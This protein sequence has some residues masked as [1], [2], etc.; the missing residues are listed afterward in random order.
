MR[1]VHCQCIPRFVTHDKIEHRVDVCRELLEHFKTEG[2]D[3]LHNIVTVDKSLMNYYAPE[4]KQQSSQWKG[5]QSPSPVE[6]TA[7][8][9]AGEGYDGHFLRSHGIHSPI[10]ASRED[11]SHEGRLS[12]DL[13]A[14]SIRFCEK[15][16]AEVHF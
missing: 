3:F 1:H 16:P 10:C 14:I 12:S 13:E 11:D 8:Q 15:T 7:A 6:A 9:S 5:H 2:F 4:A